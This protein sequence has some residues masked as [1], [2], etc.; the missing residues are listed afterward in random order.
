[1]LTDTKVQ[2]ATNQKHMV[3]ILDSRLD[4]IEYIDNNINKCNKI[5]GMLNRLSLALS[6]KILLTVYS[7][8]DPS[9]MLSDTRMQLTTNRKYLV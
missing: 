5:V 7:K 4:F 2:L 3:K 8:D 9:L 6:R 1:M